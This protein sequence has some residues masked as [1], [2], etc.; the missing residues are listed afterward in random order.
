MIK[1]VFF[2]FL[3][4]FSFKSL[5]HSDV[6][7]KIEIIGNDRIS[8]QTIKM[9][10]DIPVEIIETVEINRI[11]KDLYSS[12]FFEEV[13]IKF[14]NETLFI[15]VKEFP[16]IENFVIKGVKSKTLLSQISE[17]LISKSRSSYNK[18]FVKKDL[19]KI[20][21]KL[22]NQGY[23]FTEIKVEA[24]ALENNKVNLEF[25]VDI[26]SKAKIKKI[27]FIGNKV[28][29]DNKLKSVIISEEYK[30]WKFISGKKYLNENIIKLD[31]RLLKNFFLNKGF[32]N[33]EV[34]SSFAKLVNVDE[35][36]LIFNIEA[37]DKVFF[38]ELDLILPTDYNAENFKEIKK[39]FS[40]IKG[41]AYSLNE[42]ENI[43]TKIELLALN[44]Q[45]ETIDV[46]INE[47][48]YNDNINLTFNIT[49]TEKFYVNRINIF[50]NDVTNENVIRNQFFLD[51]GDPFNKI[52]LSKTINNLK[53]LNFFKEVN[54]DVVDN[55]D[56]SKV[57]NITVE[58]KPTGE[59]SAGAGFG[60][61]G[62]TLMFAVKENNF[63]GN[64]ISLN[65]S[66]TIS[67]ESL[68]GQINVFNPN[69]RNTDKSIYYN[70]QA[71]ELDRLT[72]FG[73]K[74]N[75]IG[76]S[77]GTNF[78]YLEDLNLGLGLD[79]YSE[80]IETDSS[81]SS[82]QKS[83]SGN[84][85]DS[86]LNFDISYDKRNQRF[87]PTSGF[88]S[89]YSI[90]IP[91]ISKSSTLSNSFDFK[92]YKELFENNITSVGFSISA[93]NS[94]NN[95]DIKLSERLYLPSRQL[96][97]FESGRIGP[98]DGNDF[99]G[100]N[101]SASLNFSSTLPKILETNQNLDV[102]MFLDAA[103]LWGV[104]YDSSIDDASGL[105]SSI[106][107]AIDWLTPVGPLSFSLAQPITKVSTDVTESFRFNLGTSF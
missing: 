28:F 1:F 30:F 64:G 101:Y 29:K 105:R 48:F 51:E 68:K 37:N 94:L 53:K 89:N 41:D 70:L 49:E 95:K 42:I 92:T 55:D 97:G 80:K 27:S 87:Q 59:I 5:A 69:F 19:D 45:Y 22:K 10:A 34:N 74:S 98:K 14:E 7:K 103:N 16:L 17:G 31:N 56:N 93:S 43:I 33:V 15:E 99:I 44:D 35:F 40:R 79:N 23:Y 6:V 8:S 106:G 102:L 38:G 66:I 75:K 47:N 21:D 65:S 71:L 78:E 39:L 11:L 104:D 73:Y 3:I 50:G 63:L 107:I 36:E 84:Y 91:A 86:F 96:R 82:R 25:L 9:F 20:K 32:Y 76:F 83:Q 4:F 57:I 52:L 46:N 2:T 12:N 67:E 18:I 13:K 62:S 60:T 26:G 24:I 88:L 58:E 100:G 77:L 90:K 61:S 54:Y 85:W 72:A 81:A